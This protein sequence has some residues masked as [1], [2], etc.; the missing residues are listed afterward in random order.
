MRHILSLACL[1]ISPAL[2]AENFAVPFSF[3]SHGN[4][5]PAGRYQLNTVAQTKNVF[6]IENQAAG[7]SRL[8]SFPRFMSAAD[9]KA[10]WVVF[11][12][13]QVPCKIAGVAPASGLGESRYGQFVLVSLEPR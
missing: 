2:F 6:R 8:V 11:D 10:A 4:M 5:M 9:E 7:K 3:H 1:L 13:T 12:C